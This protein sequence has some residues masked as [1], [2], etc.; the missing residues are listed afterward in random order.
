M[1]GTDVVE[2]HQ[3][4]PKNKIKGGEKERLLDAYGVGEKVGMKWINT[5]R[6]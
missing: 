1:A 4:R 6:W 5:G 2:N 3:I